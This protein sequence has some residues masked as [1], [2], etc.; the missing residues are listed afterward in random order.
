MTVHTPRFAFIVYIQNCR[1]YNLTTMM[2]LGK[3]FFFFFFF[4][5]RFFKQIV[6]HTPNT[7]LRLSHI[8]ICHD[9]HKTDIRYSFSHN[10][11]VLRCI[12]VLFVTT[13]TCFVQSKQTNTLLGN[14][15]ESIFHIDILIYLSTDYNS[16]T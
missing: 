2:S 9:A 3:F 1:K 14:I 15:L 13:W 7:C 4:E 16:N 12:I 11:C 10:K 6:S 5:F 8:S